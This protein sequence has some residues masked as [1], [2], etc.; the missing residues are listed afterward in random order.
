MQE[1][2][3]PLSAF[4]AEQTPPSKKVSTTRVVLVQSVCC[5]LLVLFFA[6]FKVCGGSAYAQLKSA[7]TDAIA[8]NALL[9]TVVQLL[10]APADETYILSDGTTANDKSTD[11]TTNTTAVTTAGTT[12]QTDAE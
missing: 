9:A 11:T 7:F 12:A 8:N 1:Q 6:L 2:G 3:M 4:S 10:D 5:A